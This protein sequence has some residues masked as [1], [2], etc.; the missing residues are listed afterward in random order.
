V[1]KFDRF[2]QY[3]RTSPYY[4]VMSAGLAVIAFFIAEWIG[5]SW[6]TPVAINNIFDVPWEKGVTGTLVAFSFGALFLDYWL[7]FSHLLIFAPETPR[8]ESWSYLFLFILFISVSLSMNYFVLW[9][10]MFTLT[11]IVAL[12]KVR[13]LKNRILG[14]D[15]ADHPIIPTIEKMINWK[16]W[17]SGVG[18]FISFF[19]L[20]VRVYLKHLKL[21]LDTA[22]GHIVIEIPKS[23]DVILPF[24]LI[25]YIIRG[26]VIRFIPKESKMVEPKIRDYINN[27][28]DYYQRTDN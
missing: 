8:D 7:H 5:L 27:K 11:L 24:V 25:Y 20:L 1:D 23:I 12:I 16:K 4:H 13:A 17:Y 19:I 15:Q 26:S 9:P 22:V 18:L 2:L 6:R 28:G 14:S 10:F 21:D 3:R